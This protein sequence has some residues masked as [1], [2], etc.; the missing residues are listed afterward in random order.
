MAPRSSACHFN[1]PAEEVRKLKA[2]VENLEKINDGLLA[3]NQE[4][5]RIEKDASR[6]DF[7]HGVSPSSTFPYENEESVWMMVKSRLNKEVERGEW[8]QCL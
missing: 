8:S 3:H 1:L 5:Y 2:R 7:F 4:N 6:V